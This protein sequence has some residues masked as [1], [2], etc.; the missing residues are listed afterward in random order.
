MVDFLELQFK[1]SCMSANSVQKAKVL[2]DKS[3]FD[4]VICDHNMPGQ[5]GI[6]LLSHIASKRMSMPFILFTSELEI[7]HGV[8][9]KNYYFV[10][11]KS[12]FM[13][14]DLFAQFPGFEALK[15]PHSLQS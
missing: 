7:S 5:T 15:N 11:G 1:V 3:E 6:E 2:L 12:Y 13:V 14:R 4:A 10:G 9:Y 8:E